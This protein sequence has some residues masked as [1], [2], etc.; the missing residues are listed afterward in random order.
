M[1]KILEKPARKLFL[2]D[3]CNCREIIDQP[4]PGSDASS[5]KKWSTNCSGTSVMFSM[6]TVQG[7]VIEIMDNGDSLLLDDGTAVAQVRGCN[8]IPFQTSKPVK[9]HYIMVVGQLLKTGQCPLLRAIKLQNLSHNVAMATIWPLEVI[10]GLQQ[11][12]NIT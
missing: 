9:G 5:M 1:S 3:L 4:S 11:N 6:V 12:P 2:V 8:K 10:D 7:V